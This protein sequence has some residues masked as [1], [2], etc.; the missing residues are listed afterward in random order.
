MWNKNYGKKGIETLCKGFICGYSSCAPEELAYDG[1]LTK[2]IKNKLP[3]YFKWTWKI[4]ADMKN[5]TSEQGQTISSLFIPL[6]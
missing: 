2:F 3:N 4:L 6:N 1:Y 5:K